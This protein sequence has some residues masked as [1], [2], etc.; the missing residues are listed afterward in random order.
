M[1]TTILPTKK[2]EVKKPAHNSKKNKKSVKTFLDAVRMGASIDRACSVTGISKPTYY[3]W[4]EQDPG[5]GL[6][7][8]QAKE[9]HYLEMQQS[10][11]NEAVKNGNGK[12]ALEYL[13]ARNQFENNSNIAINI[14]WVDGTGKPIDSFVEVVDNDPDKM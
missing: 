11:Y 6:L 14:A 10:V 5:L 9:L 4:K 1:S 8:E 13:K 3:N 7:V 2:E 12:L